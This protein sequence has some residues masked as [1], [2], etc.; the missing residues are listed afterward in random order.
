MDTGNGASAFAFF[1]D[2]SFRYT[3]SPDLCS[4]GLSGWLLVFVLLAGGSA[5]VCPSASGFGFRLPIDSVFV[6]F[7]ANP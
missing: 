1:T 6:P 4:V 2:L 5:V 7:P 3:T